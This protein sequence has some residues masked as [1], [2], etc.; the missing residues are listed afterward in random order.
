MMEATLMMT[1][2]LMM[3]PR[4]VRVNLPLSQ[5]MMTVRMTVEISD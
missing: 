4:L 2:I 3:L 1:M 5:M